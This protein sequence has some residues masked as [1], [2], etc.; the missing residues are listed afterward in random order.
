MKKNLTEAVRHE[1]K[2]MIEAKREDL[3]TGNDQWKESC[4]WAYIHSDVRAVRLDAEVFISGA[5]LQ[6]VE[7][8]LQV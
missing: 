5:K 1:K 3:L 7:L 2:A 6:E 4:W 8:S